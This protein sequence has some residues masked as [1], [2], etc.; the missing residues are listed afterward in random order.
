MSDAVGPDSVVAI[1]HVLVR[2]LPL[3]VREHPERS[4]RTRV[5]LARET[6]VAL[7]TSETAP[8]PGQAPILAALLHIGDAP[9]LLDA[10]NSYMRATDKAAGTLGLAHR[11]DLLA[12]EDGPLPVWHDLGD[13]VALAHLEPATLESWGT[14]TERLH[15]ALE[16]PAAAATLRAT[17]ESI[18]P[19]SSTI[20][21]LVPAL[22]R[23]VHVRIYDALLAPFEAETGGSLVDRVPLE[24]EEA[25]VMQ[26]PGTPRVPLDRAPMGDRAHTLTYQVKAW[27][28]VKIEHQT[29]RDVARR[30]HTHLQP[31]SHADERDIEECGCRVI[32]KR[33]VRQVSALFASRV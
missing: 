27:W 24:W 14:A 10:M 6:L 15:I 16:R 31:R 5:T 25:A 29:I 26:T 3:R 18:P 13:V 21:W 22:L 28:A 17:L 32:V 30:W 20:G 8:T 1:P 4:G 9:L 33:G 12:R 2:P 7:A 23:W 11:R 19:L